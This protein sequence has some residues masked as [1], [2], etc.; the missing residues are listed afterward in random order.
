MRRVTILAV[1]K[2]KE[3]YLQAA[4]AEYAKRLGRYT[5]FEVIECKEERLPRNPSAL[6]ITAALAKEGEE[7]LRRIPA[8]ATVISLCIEGRL[9]SSEELAETIEQLGHTT[10]HVVFVL[11][12]SHGLSPEVKQYSQIKL[13]FSP[14][15]FPHQ[16]MRVLLAEQVYRA[17]SINHNSQYHK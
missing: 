9:Y 16:L 5:Q 12:S 10:S 8:Q 2:L 4:V 14:M 11:G 17:F 3:K 1:G 13:S 7:I 15:T 6:E